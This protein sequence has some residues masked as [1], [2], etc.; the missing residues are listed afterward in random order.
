MVLDRNGNYV[1]VFVTQVVS[2][3]ALSEILAMPSVLCFLIWKIQ[4]IQKIEN[5]LPT[6]LLASN[7]AAKYFIH[8]LSP[9]YVICL[10]KQ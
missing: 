7:L 10:R 4:I 9:S 1:Q 8:G 2:V 6:S 3:T 5:K